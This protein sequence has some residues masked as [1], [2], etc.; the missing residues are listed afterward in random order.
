MI[1]Y[2]IGD[3]WKYPYLWHREENDGEDAGRKPRPCAVSIFVER[4][5]GQ[6][7]VTLLAITS[8]EPMADQVSIQVPD[9]EKRRA[10]LDDIPLWIIVNEHNTD[11]PEKSYYF[12]P[13]GKIGSFS[14]MFIKEVQAAKI[15]AI[16]NKKSVDVS[17]L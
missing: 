9:I 8:T 10:K 1:E 7:E 16:Q 17:R 13:N 5:D 15:K 2:K 11:T 6:I 3:V 4:E 14:S 12:E